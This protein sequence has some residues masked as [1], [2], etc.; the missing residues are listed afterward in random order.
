MG[1]ARPPRLGLGNRA[2]PRADRVY[3]TITILIR[4]VSYWGSCG[5]GLRTKE[6]DIT[7]HLRLNLFFDFLT[8]SLENSL[9]N[10]EWGWFDFWDW[11][12]LCVCGNDEFA[13]V[14]QKVGSTNLES[15]IKV[16]IKKRN[17]LVFFLFFFTFFCSARLAF[18]FLQVCKRQNIS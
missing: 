11:I 10:H 6:T 7:F 12:F 14:L 15:G 13:R 5:D 8:N 3:H 1:A 17:E 18:L 9:Q 16:G 4:T 2:A